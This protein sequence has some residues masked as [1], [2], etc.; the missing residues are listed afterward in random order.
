MLRLNRLSGTSTIY[1]KK[2][3]TKIASNKHDTVWGLYKIN[4]LLFTVRF[5]LRMRIEVYRFGQ[6]STATQLGQTS[7][8]DVLH[9]VIKLKCPSQPQG[10]ASV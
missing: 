6:R 9:V 3:P 10:N 8:L 4:A 5:P 2:S 1:V 7:M